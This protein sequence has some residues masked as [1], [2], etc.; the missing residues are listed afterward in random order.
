MKANYFFLK[1]KVTR[2][3]VSVAPLFVTIFLFNTHVVISRNE[4]STSLTLLFRSFAT[5]VSAQVRSG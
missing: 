4:E 1:S 2:L 3:Q 5:E